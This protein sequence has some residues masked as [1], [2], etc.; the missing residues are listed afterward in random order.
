M[1]R[2]QLAVVVELAEARR[3][4]RS[5]HQ[6]FFSR[7]SRGTL[8]ME[9]PILRFGDG[10]HPDDGLAERRAERLALGVGERRVA[11]L[12]DRFRLLARIG[13]GGGLHQRRPPCPAISLAPAVRS[14][15]TLD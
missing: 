3:V 9:S 6:S 4:S 14:P 11:R 7:Q 10:L 2:P 5:V 12:A 15:L 8:A 1:V 13:G